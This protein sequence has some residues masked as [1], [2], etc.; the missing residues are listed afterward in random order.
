MF[1]FASYSF[2]EQSNTVLLLMAVISGERVVGKLL[3]MELLN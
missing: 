2:A 3:D 1:E